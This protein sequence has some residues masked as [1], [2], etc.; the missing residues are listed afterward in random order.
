M[1]PVKDK[2]RKIDNQLNYYGKYLQGLQKSNSL[3]F[4]FLPSFIHQRYMKA[5]MENITTGIL[6]T[7]FYLN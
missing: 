2:A 6:V 3:Y 4:R 7:Y 1:L 5:L